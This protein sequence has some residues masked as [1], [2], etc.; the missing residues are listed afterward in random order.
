MYCFVKETV[1]RHLKR[2]LDQLIVSAYIKLEIRDK[3]VHNHSTQFNFKQL[4]FMLCT[5]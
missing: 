3:G 4:K 5:L 2:I 1:R